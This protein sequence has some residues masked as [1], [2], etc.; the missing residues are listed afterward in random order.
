MTAL[1]S[2]LARILA[3][4]SRA[5]LWL[6]A[7]GLVTMTL[8]VAW[9]V[10][11]RKILND[12]PTWTE[13][14]ALLLMSWF[15]LFGAAVCLREGEHMG[16]DIGLHYAPPPLRFAMKAVTHVLIIIFGLYMAVYG[17]QLTEK[18]WSAKM[19]GI[20]IPQG[21][22]YLP[23]FAGGILFALFAFENLVNQI[24]HRRDTFVPVPGGHAP[25][26]PE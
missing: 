7:S 26:G 21:M 22:D 9:Q 25:G 18:T 1:A 2:L 20:N 15:I 3:P 14:A 16:F 4:I 6:A 17:W 11:G 12:T 24:A 13:P 19:A 10:F 23:L 5:C 8:A